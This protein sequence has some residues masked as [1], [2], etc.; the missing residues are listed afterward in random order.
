MRINIEEKNDSFDI[1]S[2]ELP[3]EVAEKIFKNIKFL[4]GV[5]YLDGT[6]SWD[7]VIYKEK[8]INHKEKLS[9]QRQKFIKNLKE[10]AGKKA[11]TKEKEYQEYKDGWNDCGKAMISANRF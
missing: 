1:N 10:L 6:R 3:F 2:C 4:G 9:A 8:V 11:D 5:K 7:A